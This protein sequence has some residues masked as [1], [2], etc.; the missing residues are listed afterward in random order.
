MVSG[1]VAIGLA[2]IRLAV[3]GLAVIRLAVIGFVAFG[4][5]VMGLAATGLRATGF[6]AIGFVAKG[7][8]LVVVWLSITLG[9]KVT[10]TSN[11][12]TSVG[13]QE[14]RLADSFAV[15]GDSNIISV[16]HSTIS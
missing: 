5:A 14:R 4:L 13:V 6:V 9:D 1:F 11:A 3:I 10:N 8:T 2:V 12:A 7:L 16:M 15:T